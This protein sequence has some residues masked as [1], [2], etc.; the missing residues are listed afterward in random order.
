[1]WRA[2]RDVFGPL[3]SSRQMFLP[4]EP[5]TVA[6]SR[7]PSVQLRFEGMQGAWTEG[8]TWRT[9]HTY[10]GMQPWQRR[11]GLEK[12]NRAVPCLGHT[13]QPVRGD[14]SLLVTLHDP[15]CGG[16]KYLHF[17][18]I[19]WLRAGSRST[20]VSR[21]LTMPRSGP[22]SMVPDDIAKHFKL[23]IVRL[24]LYKNL[25]ALWGSKLLNRAGFATQT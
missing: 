19:S 17:V 10:R 21:I 13:C 20:W 18:I 3:G 4:T 5:Q 7:P 11:R 14:A 16:R 15:V 12:C 6:L 24:D 22:L 2:W 9:S 1:M 23:N 8:L 25:G